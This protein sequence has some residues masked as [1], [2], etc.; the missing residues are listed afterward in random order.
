MDLTIVVPA[1]NEEGNI[2]PLY[3]ALVHQLDPL[4]L[5]WDFI[6][7]DDGSTDGTW[8]KI[9]QLAATDGRVFGIHLSRNFG[10]Q[11]ALF[12]GL[13]H[14]TGRAVI[15]MDSDMQHPPHV[16]PTLVEKWQ[17]GYQIVK[18]V[19]ESAGNLPLVKSLTSDW[20][21]KIFT[22]LS[23]VKIKA[24]ASD[25]RL[26][27][28][29]VLQEILQL[30]ENDIFFRGV[31]EWVGYESCDVHYSVESRL[32]GESKY[33]VLRMIAFAWKG[34]SSFSV[35]PLRIAVVIGLLTSFIAFIATFYAVLS[36]FLSGEVV[37][38]WASSLALTSFLFGVMFVFLGVL[39]EYVGRILIEVR[40]RPRFLISQTTALNASESVSTFKP[41]PEVHIRERDQTS[42]L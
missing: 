41:S 39:G 30:G 28:Q 25:F 21:Y 16:I 37:S 38:G 11:N 6:A 14:A 12:A 29:A 31:V 22:Y 36:K 42:I 4:N 34:V 5:S 13:S 9:K 15:S 32:S 20:F 19:R 35:V 3:R 40:G 24:G 10:H 1:H 33:T 23:G 8:K 2:E 17:S 7:V 18:T 26:L 27:D